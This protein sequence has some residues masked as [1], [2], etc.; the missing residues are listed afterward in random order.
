[1]LL[2]KDHRIYYYKNIDRPPLGIIPL[3]DA[4]F[5]FQ[6]GSQDDCNWPRGVDLARTI[7]IVTEGRT[8]YAYAG[9]LAEAEQWIEQLAFVERC[10]KQKQKKATG[11]DASRA[12]K[13][14]MKKDKL[15]RQ[16]TQRFQSSEAGSKEESMDDNEI[17]SDSSTSDL[18]D[19]DIQQLSDTM[20]TVG[21][22]ATLDREPYDK[23][24]T[25]EN[26]SHHSQRDDKAPADVAALNASDE[27]EL[28]ILPEEGKNTVASKTS[29]TSSVPEEKRL[30]SS[31]LPPPPTEAVK[32]RAD[33][34]QGIY[35]F[36]EDRLYE[37]VEVEHVRIP[38]GSESPTTEP[39]SGNQSQP[40]PPPL[41][42]QPVS[43]SNVI[44]QAPDSFEP[45]DYY[46]AVDDDHGKEQGNPN[47]AKPLILRP[48]LPVTGGSGSSDA[49]EPAENA[50]DFYANADLEV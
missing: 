34:E 9:T 46:A 20:M 13:S 18:E 28:Y 49:F 10:Q 24:D 47:P 4:V 30:L 22:Y 35:E 39:K 3:T 41:P 12:L 5:S 40:A 23:P 17:S 16:R 38:D 45:E 43:A 25:N 15:N 48:P 33:T 26:G 44:Q 29:N 27:Q 11:G 2:R 36:V 42:K 14:R 50:D 32:M 8:F 37:S 19:L 21:V 7:T 1:M 6:Q 31:P